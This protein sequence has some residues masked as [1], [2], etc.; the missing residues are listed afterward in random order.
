MVKVMKSHRPHVGIAGRRKRPPRR[1]ESFIYYT[2]SNGQTILEDDSQMT[3]SLDAPQAESP[4][5]TIAVSA[6]AV[7]PSLRKRSKRDASQKSTGIAPQGHDDMDLSDELH[8][9]AAKTD[10]SV[11]VSVDDD[12]HKLNEINESNTSMIAIENVVNSGSTVSF[13][14]VQVEVLMKQLKENLF[15]VK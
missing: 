9:H 12:D 6:T 14:E 2:A 11:Q 8:R 1:D 7:T 4:S 3:V 15:S 5:S 10:T 13:H